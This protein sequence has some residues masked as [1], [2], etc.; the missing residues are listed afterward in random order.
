[1]GEAS[2][3]DDLQLST[4]RI[5]TCLDKFYV[6]TRVTHSENVKM[7][8]YMIWKDDVSLNHL[9]VNLS[10]FLSDNQVNII[11]GNG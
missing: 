6:V 1:M 9:L 2:Y 7:I 10:I 11:I 4:S 3:L 5:L 8:S